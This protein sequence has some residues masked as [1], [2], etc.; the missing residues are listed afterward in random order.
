MYVS[1]WQC[2]YRYYTNV[3]RERE[4]ERD[5]RNGMLHTIYALKRVVLTM[6][7]LRFSASLTTDDAGCFALTA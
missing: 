5:G 2:D 4:R 3:K 7:S 6:F 1:L